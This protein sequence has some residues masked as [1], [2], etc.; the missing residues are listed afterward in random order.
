MTLS[1]L[2]VSP[3]CFNK[4]FGFLHHL[5]LQQVCTCYLG[6][7]HQTL[8]SFSYSLWHRRRWRTSAS[9]EDTAECSGLEG[10]DGSTW[11]GL[12]GKL[13]LLTTLVA[14][15]PL[16]SILTSGPKS[17]ASMWLGKIRACSAS[18]KQYC[19]DGDNK[20]SKLGKFSNKMSS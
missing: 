10:A 12:L 11:E 9:T 18:S 20:I 7:I 15:Q 8:S 5:S 1:P 19:Y 6:I 4:N 16:R 13:F 2:E 17:R 3:T 14:T